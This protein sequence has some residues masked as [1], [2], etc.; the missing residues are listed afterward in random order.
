M[1][2]ITAGRLQRLL[3]NLDKEIAPLKAVFNEVD[4]QL[5]H[6]E[7]VQIDLLHIVELETFSSVR[8]YHLA[9]KLK[10]VRLERRAVKDRWEELKIALES[11][12][13]TKAKTKEQML[14][15]YEKRKSL[16]DRKYHIRKLDGDFEILADGIVSKK[17]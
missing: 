5:K 3:V 6:I 11:L 14:A 8:G 12:Q 2:D 4:R 13:E 16:A 1:K 15:I 10:E 7:L 17:K 9:K